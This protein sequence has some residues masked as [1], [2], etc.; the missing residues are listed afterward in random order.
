MVPQQERDF[1]ILH[2][3]SASPLNNIVLCTVF[4]YMISGSKMQSC[5]LCK[6]KHHCKVYCTV[7]GIALCWVLKCAGYC[8][9]LGIALYC[10]G[11]CI[12]LGI[13]L[14]CAGYCTAL[15]CLAECCC[16]W[17]PGNLIPV[18]FSPL[19]G[20]LPPLNITLY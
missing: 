17:F 19:E 3:K 18:H 14:H 5:A 11:Y 10:A 13:A 8:I 4:F 7:L 9:V 20:G 1:L 12:A 16:E 2:W 15:C 6:L